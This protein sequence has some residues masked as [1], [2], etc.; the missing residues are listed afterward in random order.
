MQSAL[1]GYNVSLLAYGQTGA[2]KTHTML[3]GSDDHR[4][5]IP[6]SIEQILSSV[7]QGRSNGWHYDL[8]VP[9]SS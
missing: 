8:E 5:I 9:N 3:G 6:R 7:E 2:G 4:G 1:D